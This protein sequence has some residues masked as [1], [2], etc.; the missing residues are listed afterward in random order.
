MVYQTVIQLGD[1]ISKIR[2]GGELSETDFRN[3]LSN[4]FGDGLCG[5]K[6]RSIRII[7]SRRTGARLHVLGSH[8]IPRVRGA[9]GYVRSTSSSSESERV[10]RA[11]K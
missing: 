3:L 5:A 11:A 10:V 9:D 6:L 8:P 4:R 7:D 1:R 2:R